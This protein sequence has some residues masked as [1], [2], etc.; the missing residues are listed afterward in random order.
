[1]NQ[2]GKVALKV[3]RFLSPIITT[4]ISIK[5]EEIQMAHSLVAKEEKETFR[6]QTAVRSRKVL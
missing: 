5:P 2:P 4:K 1:M 3:I 6:Y